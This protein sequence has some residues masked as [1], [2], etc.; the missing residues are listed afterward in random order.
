MHIKPSPS[1]SS[2]YPSL[3]TDI[4]F[5]SKTL[6]FIDQR[7]FSLYEKIQVSS[8]TVTISPHLALSASSFTVQHLPKTNLKKYR[9]IQNR[10]LICQRY[11]SASESLC[12]LIFPGRFYRQTAARF[13]NPSANISQ[14]FKTC[15]PRREE[16][17]LRNA[18]P[19]PLGGYKPE[20]AFQQ[21]SILRA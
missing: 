21:K 1:G 8:V 18:E 4:N 14:D 17:S 12:S 16:G 15:L 2:K 13:G 5:L 19:F 3:V 9:V 11:L 10:D 20:P 7:L 6:R